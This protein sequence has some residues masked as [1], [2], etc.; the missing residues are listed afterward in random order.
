MTLTSEARLLHAEAVRVLSDFRRLNEAVAGISATQVGTLTVATNPAPSSSWL[1]AVT[2]AFR[3]SRPQVRLRL[4]TRSSA[5]V[6]DEAASSAFDLGL[7]EAPF[8]RLNTLLRRY[9]FARVAVLP[10]DHR[11]AGEAVL[12][13]ALLDNEPMVATVMSN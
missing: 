1:P 5:E 13:P 6:R 3:R 10:K 7:A 9:T 4:L 11:L 8:V 2:A 12:T